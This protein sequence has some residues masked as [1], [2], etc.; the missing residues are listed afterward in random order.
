MLAMGSRA[1]REARRLAEHATSGPSWLIYGDRSS[2]S[3]R[4][5]GGSSW[6]RNRDDGRDLHEHA[7]REDDV[8]LQIGEDDVDEE[9]GQF[10]VVDPDDED[11]HAQSQPACV[12]LVM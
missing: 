8:R 10:D 4:G 1:D 9:G 2:R 12:A 11:E 6:G 7:P 5:I 3:T